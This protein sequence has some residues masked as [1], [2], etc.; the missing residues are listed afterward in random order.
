[1]CGIWTPGRRSVIF[2][3]LLGQRAPARAKDPD[4]VIAPC[5]RDLFDFAT[6]KR[7]QR[8]AAP[9]LTRADLLGGRRRH[10]RRPLRRRA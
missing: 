4:Q 1:M 9:M 6:L 10:R 2:D 5:A 3:L 7:A 8:G